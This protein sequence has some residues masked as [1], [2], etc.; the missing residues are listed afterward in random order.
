[1]GRLNRSLLVSKM[2]STELPIGFE[3]TCVLRLLGADIG[4]SVIRQNLG[5]EDRSIR[6]G[7]PVSEAGRCYDPVFE[8]EKAGEG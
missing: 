6:D 2:Y 3:A 1:M 4:D 5:L 7:R 8:Y